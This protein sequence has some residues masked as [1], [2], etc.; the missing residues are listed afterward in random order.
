MSLLRNPWLLVTVLWCAVLASAAG[1]VYTK[2][3]S[4]ELFVE[5]ERLHRERDRLDV[6]WGQWQTEQS[7]FSAHAQVEAVATGRLGM[8][9][10]DPTKIQLV[11]P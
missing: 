6:T 3:R 2:H 11:T 9:V 7:T 1:A 8:T 4:R 5:L 10:P